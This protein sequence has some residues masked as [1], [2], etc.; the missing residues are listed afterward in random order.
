MS[1]IALTKYERFF[2]RVAPAAIL[3]LGLTLGAAFAVLGS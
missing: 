2:D 1:V 3:L